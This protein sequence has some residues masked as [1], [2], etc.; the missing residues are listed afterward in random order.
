[1][2]GVRVLVSTGP[3]RA[4]HSKKSR[5]VHPVMEMNSAGFFVFGDCEIYKAEQTCICTGDENEGYPKGSIPLALGF[6]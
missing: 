5:R 3:L 4:Q 1:M 2:G 6:Q